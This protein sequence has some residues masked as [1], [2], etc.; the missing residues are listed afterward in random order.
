MRPAVD[1]AG[2]EFDLYG[3]NNPPPASTLPP[4]HD[5]SVGA[6]Q[7]GRYAGVGI[8]FQSDCIARVT[9]E[10]ESRIELPLTQFNTF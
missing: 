4:N 3:H 1:A 2:M 6:M 10:N 9:I 8:Y 5:T 7:S